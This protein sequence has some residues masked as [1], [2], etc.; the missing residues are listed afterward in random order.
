VALTYDD[1]AATTISKWAS[2][3]LA[4]NIYKA[5]PLLYWLDRKSA[6]KTKGGNKIW[7][8]IGFGKNTTVMS[9]SGYEQLDLTPQNNETKAE[10]DWK[11]MAA[12]VVISGYEEAINS[13]PEAIIDLLET[14][15][16]DAENSF[17]EQLETWLMSDGT[18]NSGKDP[19]GIKGIVSDSSTLGGIAVADAAWWKSNTTTGSDV[20]LTV[21]K[22]NTVYNTASKGKGKMA[23]DLELTTQSLFEAYEAL[24]Q[25]S[26]RYQD[27]ATANAGFENLTHK[28]AVVMWSE[29]TTAKY[30]YFLNSKCLKFVQHSD[31]WMKFRGFKDL[32]DVDA[33]FGLIL[34]MGN[35][36]CNNRRNM[37]VH[38]V[39][40]P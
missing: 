35:L 30:W 12:S 18:G 29:F 31:R 21:G 34:S 32:P 23:P 3:S 19:M 27:V 5:I 25:P 10:Y 28:S 17:M 13:G 11:Q 26:V 33:K 14:R 8:P 1:V 15:T 40:I 16:Q 2:K 20:T 37:A 7:E 6:V 9:Y 36:V 38:T 22:L 4:D 39:L 24:L